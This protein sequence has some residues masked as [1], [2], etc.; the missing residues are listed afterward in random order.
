[1]HGFLSSEQKKVLA[2][3]VKGHVV[4]DFGAGPLLMATELTALGARKVVAVDKSLPVQPATP[5]IVL[6]DIRFENWFD[7]TKIAFV[8]WPISISESCRALKRICE[9]ASR[10]VYLGK[11]TDGTSCGTPELLSSFLFRDLLAYAP[12]PRNCLIVLGNFLHEQRV[13]TGEEW[14]GIN[15]DEMW[16]FEEAELASKRPRKQTA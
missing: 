4:H 15:D 16:S 3:F 7:P 2:P 1:M 12:D 14:A 6:R 10:V 8:S 11:N 9:R 13:P 5:D